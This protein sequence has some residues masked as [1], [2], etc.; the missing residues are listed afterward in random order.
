MLQDWPWETLKKR[1][2]LYIVQK[3]RL[4]SSASMVDKSMLSSKSSFLTNG[5][6]VSVTVGEKP[7]ANP[8]CFDA[9]MSMAMMFHVLGPGPWPTASMA[10]NASAWVESR[11]HE[12]MVLNNICSRD[13]FT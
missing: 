9:V 5:V 7:F 11:E 13:T 4:L 10:N 2:R 3:S 6:L 12:S 8:I 1:S